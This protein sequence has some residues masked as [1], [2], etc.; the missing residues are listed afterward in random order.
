MAESQTPQNPGALTNTFTK[1]MVKDFNDTFV[2]EGLWT[3]ARGA[4][5][6]SHDGQIGVISNEPA[7][8]RCVKL[9]Y[10]LIGCIHLTDDQWA[11]FLTD[12][13]DS[14]IGIFDES[15]C[16]YEKVVNDPCLNFKRSH[17]I[18]GASR[19]RYDCDRIVY[20][21]DG[22]LNPT[23]VMNLSKPPFKYTEKLINDCLVKTFSTELDC[24]A[25]RLA[26]LITFPC[27]RLEKGK[28]AGTL[29]NGSY[30]VAIAYRV[31]AS[32]VTDYLGLSEVQSVFHHDNL[33][34]S[35][36]VIIEAIDTDF[37]EF[38]LAL[39]FNANQ[40][41]VAHMIGVYST[42]IGRIFIDRVNQ[43]NPTI[44]VSQIVLRTEPVE[45]VD[46]LYP[47]GSYLLGVGTYSKFKFNYQPQANRIQARWVAVQY[48]SDYYQKG[49]N[50]TGY[51]RDEQ[52]SFF[53]RWVYNTGERSESYHI[54]GRAPLAQDLQ[55]AGGD[56][57][58]ETKEGQNIKRWQ[59]ENT[60]TLTQIPNQVLADGGVLV[61][62]G[63]M[64][65][66]ESTERY[67]ADK[68]TI[69]GEL[70]GK[71]IRHHK[72]PDE[73]V[74]PVL[75]HFSSNGSQIVMLGVEFDNISH[76]LDQNQNPIESI[77]GYEILRGSREG[78]KTI[79]AKGIL[80]NMR[81]YTIPGNT[82]KGLFQNYPYNDLRPDYYLTTKE[83]NGENGTKDAVTQPMSGYK[84]DIFSFHSPEVSFSNPFINAQELK[85]YTTL[86]GTANGQ[87]VTPYKHPKFKVLSNFSGILSSL[88]GIL[89]AVSA[90]TKGVE[91]AATEG[92]PITTKVGPI[93]SAAYQPFD[94][95]L[96]GTSFSDPTA[97]TYNKLIAAYNKK[98]ATLET[99]AKI[100]Q[101]TTLLLQFDK[102]ASFNAE[103]M[104]ELIRI[105]VPKKQYAAQYISHGFYDGFL[106][107]PSGNRRRKILEASYVG[108]Q[109]QQFNLDYQVN[110]LNRSRMVV[111]QTEDRLAD[112]QTA[113][114]SRFTLGDK[115]TSLYKNNRSPIASHYGALK[116]PM[117]SQ[118]GQLDSIKQLPISYCVQSTQPVK[119]KRYASPIL[120]GGDTYINRFTEKN[121][122]FFFTDW[123]MGEKDEIEYDYT[124]YT[125]VPYP[126]YWINNAEP[127]FHVVGSIVNGTVAEKASRFRV[128]DARESSAFH[129]SKG[130]FYLFNS[131]VRDFFVESE[132]NLAYRDWEEALDKRHY[133][134]Y[135]FT[136]AQTMFR[137]D[138]IRSGN[139]Y[140]YD[141]SLSVSKLVQSS[142]TWGSLLPRDYDPDVA[143]KCYVYRPNRVIYSLPQNS[144]SRKDGWRNFLANNYKD[145]DGPVSSVKPINQTG[146]LFMMERQS[147]LQFVGQEQ[148]QMDGS[149]TK[150]T[151]G[152][153]ALFS[154]AQQLQTIVNAD[155]SLEYG[156]CQNRYAVVSTPF[157]IFWASQNQ[158][159]IFQY[160]GQ[161]QEI[162]REGM[163]YWFNRYLPSELLKVYPGYPLKDNALKGVGVQIVYDSTLEL[164]YVTKKDYR[165]RD[166][167]YSFDQLG[168]FY[169]DP[170]GLSAPIS[171]E[172]PN[173]FEDASWTISYDPKTKTWISFH[174]WH[175]TFLLPARRHFLSV[176]GDSIW[177]H[178]Q[179]CDLFCNFYGKDYPFEVEFVSASGQAVNS[180]RSVEYL[181][182]CYRYYNE[183]QDKLHLLDENFDSAMI[184]NSEQVS[185][186]LELD[187]KQKNNPFAMLSYPQIGPTSI[188]IQYA[189]EEQKYRF[190]QFWDI[191]RNRG[192]FTPTQQPMFVTSPNGYQFQINPLFVDYQKPILQRKKFRHHANRVWLRKLKSGDVKMLFKISNQKL[193][194]SPR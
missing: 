86:T 68:Q 8:L 20:W 1:G 93:Q 4:V 176:N 152:D 31:G 11:V 161:L 7:N 40:Q 136:D 123:L 99:T 194:P 178:N 192:E 119:T 27:L 78:N 168:N 9:P 139:F 127:R 56:D 17:L 82:T 33:S 50:N 55:N 171:L 15:A 70:C 114:E 34:S 160:A 137:S 132:I 107:N 131:G 77:V 126:R 18:L 21:S 42:S 76:P 57:A 61:A 64:G 35:L 117:P 65:Y 172:D 182:E 36:E 162:S 179:R 97:A 79:I 106:Q 187:P 29:P 60:A 169:A 37:D 39:L 53:I 92:V 185:G 98:V 94:P 46:A 167:H 134:P 170:N 180:V 100:L 155:E 81:E 28:A 177:K 191:T 158:G 87:F 148:L 140:K 138:I 133:D 115:R 32:R 43:E 95:T 47:V 109:I 157:G 159:K 84:Q 103:K 22:G 164:L 121:T 13:K 142:I 85:V 89:G 45:K 10:D 120:F 51:M 181:L 110:N 25:I 154:N 108:A 59:V 111:L 153:G 104:Y 24:E 96:A 44:P 62:R 71:P 63:Q 58:F 183:C 116:I 48:P 128:L 146:A 74:S 19:E 174:D 38:E 3:H 122:M 186:L 173:Y 112:P 175:P 23:R 16:S 113:D 125:N 190:N 2:G 69:W 30:Q 118:Y 72:M 14:E 145:L 130:Y 91:F 188:R 165:P 163:K 135:R 141:F 151:I 144:E 90:F 189:K 124:L 26:P 12:D 49:N 150:I 66:W 75:S 6:Y 184:Y 166:R 147:P 143:E 156:S 5:N 102:L 129:V 73:T 80:N 149:G 105:L 193:Q 52:Y 83:Q 41:T 54:P 67:P 101:I 88:V